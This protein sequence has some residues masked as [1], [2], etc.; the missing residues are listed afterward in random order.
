MNE[1][2]SAG[3]ALTKLRLENLVPSLPGAHV[4]ET[5]FLSALFGYRFPDILDRPV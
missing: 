1:L 3:N 4:G 5:E 2:A